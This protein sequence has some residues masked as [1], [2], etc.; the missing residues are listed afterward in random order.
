MGSAPL[1]QAGEF[2]RSF[3]R[4]ILASDEGIFE[5]DAPPGL[6][7][8]APGCGYEVTDRGGACSWDEALA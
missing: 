5:G 7:E 8:V 6:L 3:R 1:E 4:V 2:G